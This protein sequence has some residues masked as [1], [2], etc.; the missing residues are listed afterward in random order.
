MKLSVL[1][2]SAKD[3]CHL[4]EGARALQITS[5]MLKLLKISSLISAT[6]LLWSCA[7][8]PSDPT[9][10]APSEDGS[11]VT[12]TKSG[13]IW[14]RCSEGQNWSEGTCSGKARLFSYEQAIAYGKTQPGWRVPDVKELE[15][16][17]DRSRIFPAIDTKAFPETVSSGYWSSTSYAG[18]QY[19]GWFVV[20]QI[21]HVNYGVRGAGE[22]YF[23]RMVR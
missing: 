21:A 19:N 13:L 7:T 15:S 1:W 8:A 10:F 20:F 12:D 17:L 14:R 4:K 23:L 5:T 2:P 18:S 22:R 9:R 16:I 3:K 6:C 11:E